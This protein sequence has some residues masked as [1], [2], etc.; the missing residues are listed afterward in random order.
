MLSKKRIDLSKIKTYPLAERKSKI[1]INDL[2]KPYKKGSS[3]ADYCSTLPSVLAAS[4]FRAIVK[5]V[6]TAS[7]NFKPI[8]IALGAHVIKCGL[9]PIIIDLMQKTGKK[10]GML[11]LEQ[12]QNL[13]MYLGKTSSWLDGL[14][15]LD[16]TDRAMPVVAEKMY[17]KL[18][19]AI[20]TVT[21]P[22]EMKKVTDKLAKLIPIQKAII[23]RIPIEERN[24]LVNISETFSVVQGITHRDPTGILF[25]L[26]NR[27]LRSPRIGG[28]FVKA[29]SI[30]EKIAPS[31]KEA[32]RRGIYGTK[33]IGK[34]NFDV[35][36]ELDKIKQETGGIY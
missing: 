9:T 36:E 15:R 3:F 5:D 25:A 13:K 20:E 18:R 4:D 26:V 12:A 22:G 14:E 7:H 6:C 23:K 28:T 27:G 19:D 32:V 34:E 24:S 17:F 33:N 2:A 29:G 10:T 30:P 21:P 35:K 31:T 16:K 1:S 8:I 11:D